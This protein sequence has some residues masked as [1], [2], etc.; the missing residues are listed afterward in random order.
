MSCVLSWLMPTT[1][2][3]HQIW[4]EAHEKIV[5]TR[6]T[7]GRWVSVSHRWGN[8]WGNS[9][10]SEINV[11]SGRA[12]RSRIDRRP[13]HHKRETILC[14]KRN[15]FVVSSTITTY[16]FIPAVLT[17][18]INLYCNPCRPNKQCANKTSCARWYII[19][20]IP[21]GSVLRWLI[22]HILI[23]YIPSD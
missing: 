3:H 2:F 16:K 18:T 13:S 21:P 8:L 4:W 7:H 15:I 11:A 20:C 5:Y 6:Y 10:F 12:Y 14:V 9:E 1:I 17:T 22:K 23:L 19:D